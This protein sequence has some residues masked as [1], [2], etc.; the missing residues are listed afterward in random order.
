MTS[1]FAI[2]QSGLLAA[3]TRLGVSA[4]N[5]ANALTDDYTPVR[6]D[7]REV[8]GGGVAAA[9]VPA[10]DPAVAARLDAA[11]LAGTDLAGEMVAQMT[12]AAAFRANLATLRTADEM[13]GALMDVKA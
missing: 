12:A 13:A 7:A 10:D 11:H 4:H 6:V 3:E 5:V 9:P 8:A 2:A 1:T